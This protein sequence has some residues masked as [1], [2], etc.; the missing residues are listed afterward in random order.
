MLT[1][2]NPLLVSLCIALAIALVV[3]L[4]SPFHGTPYYEAVNAADDTGQHQENYFRAFWRW[5]THDP[6]AFYTSLLAIFTFV[7]AVS[8]IGLWIVTYLTL[9]HARED[10]ARQ[11]KDMDDSIR[12]AM[13]SAS[14]GRAA[15]LEMRKANLLA[16]DTRE[17][18]LRAYV[19]IA[20]GHIEAVMTDDGRRFIT[21]H[22]AFKNHGQTPGYK[23]TTHATLR[24]E[25]P[26]FFPDHETE[27]G[28]AMSAIGPNGGAQVD[29]VFGPISNELFEEIRM[30]AKR[31]FL[32]GRVDYVDAFKEARHLKFREING[33]LRRDGLSWPLQPL[34]EYEAT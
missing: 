2:L 32:W 27:I 31:I 7:L 5:T 12:A 14:A 21:G 20:E 24:I 33:R 6:V 25:A 29:R 26:S 11:A 10:A 1:R 16:A 3:E 23:F 22:V 34:G 4:T 9:R 13:Q 30:G 8:T 15:A 28:G 17:Q 18:Q 19:F